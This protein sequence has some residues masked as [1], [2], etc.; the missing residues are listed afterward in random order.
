MYFV[1]FLMISILSITGCDKV[2]EMA[3]KAKNDIQTSVTTKINNE[4]QDVVFQ[5]KEWVKNGLAPIF[6]WMF[7]IFFLLLSG[8]LKAIIPFS[9]IVI[10]QLPIVIFSYLMALRLFI[11]LD[12]T[13]FAIKGSL[14][15]FI[16]IAATCL[17][18]Y[19]FRDIIGPKIAAINA[20]FLSN[21][22]GQR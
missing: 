7:V 19:L 2:T 6:P 11:Q 22:S 12:L 17:V 3:N 20:K 1:I 18:L 16:P 4:A 8:A 14:W 13:S 10:I 9:N 21:I 15:F 5:I